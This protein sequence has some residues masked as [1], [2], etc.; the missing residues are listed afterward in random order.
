MSR[1]TPELVLRSPA[2]LNPLKDRELDLRGNRIAVVENLGVMDNGFDALDLSD[3]EIAKLDN[4]PRLTR[5]RTLLACNNRIASISDKQTLSRV[6]PP[7]SSN[8]VL[9]ACLTR[10]GVIG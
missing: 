3:N 7:H 9:T 10:S 8:R 5:L 4:F 6:S 2:F 1:I